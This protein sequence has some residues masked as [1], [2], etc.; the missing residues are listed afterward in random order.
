MKKFGILSAVVALGLAGMPAP[1][2][3]KTTQIQATGDSRSEGCAKA[4]ASA[5]RAY[6][7]RISGYNGCQ[8]APKGNESYRYYLC[9]LTVF[10]RD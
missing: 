2:L 7:D 8:C 3:A 5:K 9:T 10:Y 4:R 6:G 1:A